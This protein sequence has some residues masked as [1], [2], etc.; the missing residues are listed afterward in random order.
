M[1]RKSKKPHNR[2]P[3]SP[4][5]AA[6]PSRRSRRTLEVA[7]LG[8]TAEQ[9]RARRLSWS[10]RILLAATVFVPLVIGAYPSDAGTV[11]VRFGLALAAFIFLLLSPAFNEELVIDRENRAWHALLGVCLGAAA[12]VARGLG[13]HY[14]P[15]TG[16]EVFQGYVASLG[17]GLPALSGLLGFLP[18]VLMAGVLEAIVYAG[19]L[20]W[21]LTRPRGPLGP[22]GAALLV[23]V[24]YAWLHFCVPRFPS[25]LAHFAGDLSAATT[26]AAVG[27][28]N[29]LL[30][31]FMNSLTRSPM[32]AGTFI[33]VQ[34][35]V[36]MAMMYVGWA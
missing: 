29:G 27:A 23:S 19:M 17:E 5:K 26:Y 13:S 22:I 11:A 24:V 28:V 25:R 36:T 1:P 4:Q 32:L 15:W 34:W 8:R 2:G 35:W 14:T 33:G 7:R 10:M 31:C 16:T 6:S 21:I 20:R 12:G 3:K 9:I 30:T 18:L